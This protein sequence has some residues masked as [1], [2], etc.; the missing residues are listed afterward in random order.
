[1]AGMAKG[2]T[3]MRPSIVHT[4]VD[5][6]RLVVRA[7]RDPTQEEFDAHVSEAMRMADHVRVV[8]V[9]VED[10]AQISP[11]F[12]ARLLRSGLL[13][14][15]HAILTDSF[16]ARAEM[17]SVSRMG[18]NVRAF[19]AGALDE[20]LDFLAVPQPLRADIRARLAAMR[21]ETFLLES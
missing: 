19:A 5:D 7:R 1:M 17:A 3:I 8:L 4:M 21:R 12:R 14:P 16:L 20:A 15:R 6:V 2:S 18:G 10:R 9:L 11:A 13:E